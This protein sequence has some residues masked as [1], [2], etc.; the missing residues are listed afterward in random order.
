VVVRRPVVCAVAVLAACA[1]VSVSGAAGSVEARWV[2]R[3]LG[4]LGGPGSKAVA[5]NERGQ[6]VGTADTAA[7]AP[8]AFLWESGTMRDLGAGFGGPESEAVAINERGQV[9]GAASTV[10][11]DE[12]GHAVSHAF[13]WE[14]GKMRDL[15]TLGGRSSYAVA[16]N[17]RGQVVGSGCDSSGRRCRAFLWQNGTMRDLGTLG[18]ETGQAVAIN[19]RGQVVGTV[20]TEAKYPGFQSFAGIPDAFVW[21]DGK[22]TRLGT[23]G[24]PGSMAMAINERGQVV[25]WADTEATY[26]RGYVVGL[27]IR[28]AFL[29]QN[30]TMRDLGT[31]GGETSQAVAINERG[32][33]VGWAETKQGDM[34]VFLWQRGKMRDLGAT[35]GGED[36]PA[37]NERGQ[38]VGASCERSGRRCRAF[39]WQNGKLIDLGTLRRADPKSK[40]VAIN[41]HNQII[42][43]A[44]DHAVLWTKR[45]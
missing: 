6:V 13:L 35:F 8:H 42:G 11:I 7:G 5:I 30:G 41:G 4:T 40:A 16:V 21:Q 37:I 38:V 3:D 2:I 44:S 22:R 29:W 32:Q 10:A 43:Q 12:R 39:L 45:G 27:P 31:L 34:H 1:L 19:D 14:N 23:L 33:V 17:E 28:H 26:E 24:G 20:D 15:G 25:G 9:V 36:L 18:G